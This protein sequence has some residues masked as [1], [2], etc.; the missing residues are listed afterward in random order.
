M[1]SL[2]QIDRE[3]FAAGPAPHSGEARTVQLLPG[4]FQHPAPPLSLSLDGDWLMAAG[5]KAE[6]RL[7]G[8]FNDAIPA[9]VP[10]SI[11][12]ALLHAGRIPDPYVGKN[13]EIAR[14]ESFKTWWLLREFEAPAEMEGARLV[15][16]GICDSCAI[17]L[18][19]EKLGEHKGM[20][21][22]IV[23][24]V[25][26]RLRQ[27][28][29]QIIVRLDPA[30]YRISQHGEPNDPGNDFFIGMNVGWLDTAVINN[31]YGWH[32]INLPT[33]GIWRPVSLKSIPPVEI[34]DPFVATI[35]ARRGLMRLNV[36]LRSAEPGFKGKLSGTITPEN[37]SGDSY[38]FSL[39]VNAASGETSELLEF[40]I[41]DARLWQ[42]VDCGDPNL[43]R[44]TLSFQP[45]E[46]RRRPLRFHL[47]HS[48][49][50]DAS[51][52]IGSR[53]RDLQLDFRRQRQT[54]LRQ[55]RELVHHRRLAA[56]RARTL[57]PLHGSGA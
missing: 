23:F 1:K 55:R 53:S 29:N 15:F 44:L 39:D 22:D 43:Y 27:G 42:P 20:F 9:V 32:Y 18:N 31:I 12:T 41:P 46:R 10:G 21:A 35:D 36:K 49:N 52:A 16:G 28:A 34:V 2:D 47:R 4:A 24:D 7:A 50:R 40:T 33:L 11:Q 6:T 3:S 54:H 38:L 13:D 26:D 5:G 17:W 48:H 45:S 51:L 19:G 37:F 25:S 8:D 30:P 57:C 56:F 14:A